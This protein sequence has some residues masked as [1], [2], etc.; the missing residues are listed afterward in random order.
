MK[1]QLQCLALIVLTGLLAAGFASTSCLQSRMPETLTL[2]I[3]STEV[4]GLVYVA[5]ERHFFASNDLVFVLKN[6]DAGATAIIGM[7]KGEVDIA[8]GSEY[9][10]V[11]SVFLKEKI[12]IIGSID[13]STSAFIVALKDHGIKDISDLKGK[14][15]GVS[16]QAI[17]EF[18]LGRFFELNGMSLQ[19]VKL[20]D[21]KFAQHAEALSSGSVDAVITGEP[22]LSQMKE[23]QAGQIIVWPAN[24]SQ[25]NF[26]LLI[27]RNDWITQH[28]DLVKRFLKSLAQ[29]ESYLIQHSNEAK[30]IIQNSLKYDDA[31]MKDAWERNQFSLSL[32]LS[33]LV[34]MNDEAR[35]MIDNELTTEKTVPDFYDYIYLDGLKAVKPE[36]VNI[37]R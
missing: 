20:V 15:I 1:K 33:L 36:A 35:W 8:L 31:R 24:S 25:P 30:A 9:P 29:A 14:I 22:Y 19:D 2:G 4:A 27:G 37:T 12:S 26:S 21:V 28:P 17:A 32:E 10:I 5:Q 23:R 11:A 16:R 34:A 6:Y 7:T 3:G 13:R 18:Y